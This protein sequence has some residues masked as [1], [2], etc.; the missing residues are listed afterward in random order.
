MEY[1]EA[2]SDR[3]LED[4]LQALHEAREA[5]P[6]DSQVSWD[7]RPIEEGAAYGGAVGA[8]GAASYAIDGEPDSEGDEYVFRSNSQDDE[9]RIGCRGEGGAE[10]QGGVDG[11]IGGYEAV[12]EPVPHRGRVAIPRGGLEPRADER[13]STTE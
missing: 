10:V 13:E 1:R 6:F 3:L 11:T 2:W 9:L 8:D 5:S 7:A 4:P 12:A